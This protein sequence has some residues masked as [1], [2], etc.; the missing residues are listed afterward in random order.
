MS[1]PCLKANHSWRGDF[2]GQHG[3]P[4]DLSS[5]TGIVFALPEALLL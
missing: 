3:L 5:P 1:V 2:I 4:L